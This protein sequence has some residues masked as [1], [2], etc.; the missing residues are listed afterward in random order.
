VDRWRRCRPLD[1][2]PVV[3][4]GKSSAVSVLVEHIVVQDVE[5]VID[6]PAI[7]HRRMQLLVAG[8]GID[9]RAAHVN[10]GIE[11][12]SEPWSALS[13]HLAGF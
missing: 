7:G 2:F 10:V 1:V 8:A 13:S 11:T 3:E 4:D 5:L 12:K 6:D 9:Q